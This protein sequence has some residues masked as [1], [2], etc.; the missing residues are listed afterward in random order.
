M[1]NLK[2]N[3]TKKQ[4]ETLDK[5]YIKYTKSISKQEASELIGNHIRIMKARSIANYSYDD[6]DYD[7]TDCG[8][9][10]DDLC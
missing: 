7:G 10:F 4:L 8:L 5:F 2:G 3:A 1:K 6:Y 9:T